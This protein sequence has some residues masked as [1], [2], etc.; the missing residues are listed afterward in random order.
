[1]NGT[2]RLGETEFCSAWRCTTRSS[3]PLQQRGYL[4]RLLAVISTVAILATGCSSSG[5]TASGVKSRPA[6]EASTPTI[7]PAD[8]GTF[9]DTAAIAAA[10]TERGLRCAGLRDPASPPTDGSER[11]S[12]TT[13]DG[14]SVMLAVYPNT[15]LLATEVQAVA[16][17]SFLKGWTLFGPDVFV[18]RAHEVLGGAITSSAR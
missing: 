16:G 18:Q 11:K 3:Y 7:L 10:L 14:S 17:E 15:E 2:W 12:C 1:M 5:K 6:S 4:R 8:G 13:E 9:G